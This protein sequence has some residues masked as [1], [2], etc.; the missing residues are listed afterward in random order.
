ML[1]P[2]LSPSRIRDIGGGVIVYGRIPLMVT[3]RCFVR[4][5]GG[6]R[7]CGSFELVDRRGARFPVLREFK[8]RSLIFN[9]LPTY[10][11]DKRDQLRSVTQEHMIFSVESADEV[12]RILRASARGGELPFGVRRI[13]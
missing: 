7:S 9:S 12:R 5:V 6:C 8:H 13:K 1:S 11:G 2:E 10:M 4:E 3:E